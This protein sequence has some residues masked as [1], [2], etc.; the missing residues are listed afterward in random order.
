[1]IKANPLA[2]VEFNLKVQRLSNDYKLPGL[3]RSTCLILWW[4]VLGVLLAWPLSPEEL[5]TASLWLLS[6]LLPAA[7]SSCLSVKPVSS[8][9]FG[10]GSLT[11]VGARGSRLLVT[12]RIRGNYLHF[13]NIKCEHF[14]SHRLLVQ[15]F[16]VTKISSCKNAQNAVPQD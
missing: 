14:I 1:M 8:C 12:A 9:F 6:I 5:N 15:S 16:T 7:E 4:Y 10:V 11:V 3:T 13:T 2:E